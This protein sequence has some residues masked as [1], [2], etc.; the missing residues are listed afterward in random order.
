MYNLSPTYTL[1]TLEATSYKFYRI[2][3]T[4][5]IAFKTSG[6][7]L[8]VHRVRHESF[9]TLCFP[10]KMPFMNV[11]MAAGHECETFDLICHITFSSRD[12]AGQCVHLEPCMKNEKCHKAN[13]PGREA[14]AQPVNFYILPLKSVGRG[15]TAYKICPS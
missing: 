10:I 6:K 8:L 1:S 12:Y 14:K 2:I 15:I 3:Q 13:A 7:S 9:E 5:Y 11:I 4:V